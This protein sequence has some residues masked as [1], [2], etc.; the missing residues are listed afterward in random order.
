MRITTTVT[1][2]GNLA[3]DPT[4]RTATESGRTYA[5]VAVLVNEPDEDVNELGEKTTRP[6]T[7]HWVRVTGSAVQHAAAS[8][9]RGDLVLVTGRVVTDACDR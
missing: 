1:F 6:P 3:D 2:E 8:L 4:L 7:K 9:R 5:D